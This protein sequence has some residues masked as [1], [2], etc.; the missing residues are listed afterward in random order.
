MPA[1]LFYNK[2]KII[3][4]FAI[5]D[6]P[7]KPARMN[8]RGISFR[9]NT[10]ITSAAVLII[11]MIVYIN[12][13]L[14]NEILV[15][16]IEEGAINQS[17]LVISKISRI[18]VGT[19]EIAKNVSLQSLYHYRNEDLNQFLNQVL[20]SNTIL[21]SLHVEFAGQTGNS[22]LKFSSDKNGQMNIIPDFTE[23][24]Y[25][26]RYKSELS[27][28]KKG[29][30]TESFYSKSDSTNLLVSYILPI[31]SPDTTTVI[32]VVSCEISLTQMQKMLSEIKIGESG[33]TF[34][35]DKSGNYITHPN[36]EWVLR[37]NIYK[38][39][40]SL[41]NGNGVELDDKIRKGEAGSGY[42]FS[43][44]FD[45]QKS[46]FYF[47]PLSNADWMVITVVLHKELF[48]E[49]NLT[50]QKVLLVSGV[51]ILMLFF[52]NLFI[53]TRT[54]DPLVRVTHAIQRFSS[55][56]GKERKSKDEIKMLAESLEDWQAKYGV[57]IK[58]QTKTRSEKLRFEKDLK[59]AQEIQQNIVPGSKPA[60]SEH[61]EIDLF[62][63]L[64]PAE[65]IG[66]DLYDYF[67]I[68]K[69][70]LLIAIGDVSGKSIPASLFMAVA[71]TLIKSN[72]KILSSNA[73]VSQVN[74]EL[75]ERNSNQ[76][77]V[78]L[79]LGILDVRSGILD[80]CNAAHNYPYIL[81]G[82]GTLQVLSESH[83]L[84]LGIYK[85]K[86]YRSSIIELGINDTIVLYT[87][88]VINSRDV[89]DEH[90]GTERLENNLQ[91]MNDL[92]SEELVSKL[93]R[94]IMIY[95]GESRQADDISLMALKYLHKAE[96]QV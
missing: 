81:H 44:Y 7:I 32:G 69:N 43:P 19:E 42:C 86:T 24:G 3:N 55:S 59:S 89:H 80:Y 46:W 45:N 57:L 68:D 11:A 76:Y 90:Y 71:S 74:N 60:F 14:S 93:L 28:S 72:A 16:K 66:G 64:K 27:A 20:I 63:I 82:D 88:G 39:E 56:P 41:V 10:L 96:N 30:W 22:G 53:F 5:L 1:F 26:P 75:S 91:N 92:T 47:A 18:T 13:Y 95:S 50:F 2:S 31:F 87:D 12:F 78:T 58:D 49:I 70:H 40:V 6:K 17:N 4:L 25:L 48:Q 73:I 36:Y 65:V 38:N 83:G 29:L 23:V 79:F 15:G 33:Y 52:F 85:D 8:P 62:A 84:P 77:F 37:K 51:G 35:I 61:S 34:I 54:L 67:F 21:E 94:S 9:L